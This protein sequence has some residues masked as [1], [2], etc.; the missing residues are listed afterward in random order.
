M[1]MILTKNNHDHKQKIALSDD[2]V[3]LESGL[4]KEGLFFQGV[5]VYIFVSSDLT[6]VFV[7]LSSV[8]RAGGARCRRNFMLS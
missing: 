1:L 5:L 8:W 2:L 6:I 7:S 4:S 3:L